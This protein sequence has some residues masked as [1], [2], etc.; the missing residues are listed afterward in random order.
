MKD[1]ENYIIKLFEEKNTP[2]LPQKEVEEFITKKSNLK[3][4][5]SADY[6]LASF[7]LNDLIKNKTE[8]FIDKE[9]ENFEALVTYFAKKNIIWID[10]TLYKYLSQNP[11]TVTD[12]Q[13]LFL[14]L[15]N[16]LPVTNNLFPKIDSEKS[17]PKVKLYCPSKSC[18][19]KFVENKYGSLTLNRQQICY[20]CLNLPREYF[21]SALAKW[22][23][24]FYSFEDKAWKSSKKP[25][26][27]LSALI[28]SI[29]KE[30]YLTPLC[31]TLTDKGQLLPLGCNTRLMLAKY[32]GMESI[33]A[34]IILS[35][36]GENIR[37]ELFVNKIE[38]QKVMAEEYL[39]PYVMYNI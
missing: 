11:D 22:E 5:T 35:Y 19:T 39:K 32:L 21:T 7:S 4:L 17:L 6:Y 31:F 37:E 28:K 1:L 3:G 33:P 15:E 14:G 30:G 29:S 12:Q 26:S 16:A 36:L 38:N 8:I 34:V 25:S 18:L 13:V 20:Y 9:R 2:L 10:E 23:E 27:E 24:L